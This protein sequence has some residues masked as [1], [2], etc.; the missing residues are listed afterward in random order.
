MFVNLYRF[1]ILL[2]FFGFISDSITA[3]DRVEVRKKDNIITQEETESVSIY[4]GR[5]LVDY[6][7]SNGGLLALEDSQGQILVFH[8]ED[9]VSLKS[10]EVPFV[11]D[12]KKKIEENLILKFGESFNTLISDHFIF[13]YNTS[14]GYATW[15]SRLFE[16]LYDT[17]DRYQ[18]KRNFKLKHVEIPMVVILFSSK[19][20]FANFIERDAPGTSSNIVAYYH[21]LKNH[22]VLYDLTGGELVVP[23][24]KR[25]TSSYKK[26]E[27]ILSR[28]QSAFNVA[29]IVHEAT[30]QISFNRG[31]FPRTGPFSLWLSEGIATLF[32]SPDSSSVR[33]W[34][35]RGNL[36]RPNNYR[37]AIFKE[38]VKKNPESPIQNM[39]K[40]TDYI[41]NA[42]Y[43]YATS[44]ALYFYL[45]EKYPRQMVKYIEYLNTKPPFTQYTPEERL[46][47]F[48]DYFGSDWGLFY[49]N[50]NRF[51]QNM[52]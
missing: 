48:E 8:G 41:K 20:E 16:S 10:D 25:N 3:L 52:H 34:S 40:E 28:P 1:L 15:C 22:T 44:W 47:D 14:D 26:V 9:V 4:T 35:G 21:R 11:P 32:E 30:H 49:R 33:G 12:S 24:N 27:E 50:F 17:F 38:Y 7:T 45:N 19:Q 13:V 46:S 36:D 6:R 18:S 29:T 23:S 5:L 39:I 42:Q 43:S 2:L 51:Y 31:M 37:L